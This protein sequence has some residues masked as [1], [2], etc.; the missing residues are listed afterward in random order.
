MPQKRPHRFTHYLLFTRKISVNMTTQNPN[1]KSKR[2]KL[3][4]T[5]EGVVEIIRCAIETDGVEKAAAFFDLMNK[6]CSIADGWSEAAKEIRG[7]IAD[8][9]K[10]LRQEKLAEELALRKAGAPNIILMNQNEANGS[11]DSRKLLY[12]EQLNGLVEEGAE[13]IHTKYGESKE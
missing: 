12:A 3:K 1:T 8:A 10:Q 6:Y 9:K 13:V 11:K 2:N 4:I 7:I 5:H